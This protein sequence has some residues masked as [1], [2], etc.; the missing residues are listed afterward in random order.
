MKM[1]TFSWFVNFGRNCDYEDSKAIMVSGL[2]RQKICQAYLG[3]EGSI[4]RLR[5]LLRVLALRKR[6]KGID[7]AEQST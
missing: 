3:S 6:A 5:G 1:S 2:V 4:Y 7:R